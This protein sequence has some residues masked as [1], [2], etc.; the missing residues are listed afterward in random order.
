MTE[1]LTELT[2]A[3]HTSL[4]FEEGELYNPDQDQ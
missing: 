3:C 2:R 1:K 4:I